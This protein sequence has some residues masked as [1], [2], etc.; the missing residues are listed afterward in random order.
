MTQHP[1]DIR[2]YENFAN[3]VLV[4]HGEYGGSF[5]WTPKRSGNKEVTKLRGGKLNLIA[6]VD[7][8]VKALVTAQRDGVERA[9]ARAEADWLGSQCD[10]ERSVTDTFKAPPP[11][12]ELKG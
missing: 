4:N 11:G 9:V 12:F 5:V 8:P 1:A 6:D 7:L 2:A 10:G 3:V